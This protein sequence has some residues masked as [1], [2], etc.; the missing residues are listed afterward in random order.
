MAIAVKV[1]RQ[2]L[3]CFGGGSE[4]RSRRRDPHEALQETFPASDA[5]A[6]TVE[7]GIGGVTSTV[8]DSVAKNWKPS[9]LVL[10]G[11]RWEH[12]PR[13]TVVTD[14]KLIIAALDGRQIEHAFECC[15]LVLEFGVP[16]S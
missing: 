3:R 13:L 7:A 12:L 2:G 5:L 15:D 16:G 11:L 1:R 10:W 9:R 4:G 14:R 6:D 8:R